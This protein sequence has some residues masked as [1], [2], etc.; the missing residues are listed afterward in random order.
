ME[1]GLSL[2]RKSVLVLLISLLV[3]FAGFMMFGRTVR[4]DESGNGWTLTDEG[5]LT[6][7]DAEAFNYNQDWKESSIEIKSVIIGGDIVSVPD[8]AFNDFRTITSVDLGN[9]KSVGYYSFSDCRAL[10][11]IDLSKLEYIDSFGFSYCKSLTSVDIRNVV[12]LEQNAFQACTSLK[13]VTADKLETIGSTVFGGCSK[14]ETFTFVNSSNVTS[15]GIGCFDSCEKLT[16]LDLSKVTSIPY[17]AFG[18]CKALSDLKLGDLTSISSDSFYNCQSLKEID[19]S[20]ITKIP[21]SAF[22][23]C[24]SLLKVNLENVTSI[25]YGA[26]CGCTSLYSVS[27][28]ENVESIDRLAFKNCSALE[29]ELNL[30][31]VSSIPDEAFYGCSAITIV[32]LSTTDSVTIG[33]S[34]FY[35]CTKLRQVSDGNISSV[36]KE[37]FEFCTALINIEL[38][39]ASTIS[40]SAFSGCTKLGHAYMDNVK[41]IGTSAFASCTNMTQVRLGSDLTVIEQYTFKNCKSLMQ[42]NLQYVKEIKNE[43]FY[44]CENL[45]RADLRSVENIRANA[46]SGSFI[47]FITISPALE[48]I[49]GGFPVEQVNTL[50]FVGSKS[51]TRWDP[52]TVFPNALITYTAFDVVFVNGDQQEIQYVDKN[53]NAV[54]PEDLTMTD[55]RFTGWY[56]DNTFATLFDFNTRIT[57]D[58]TLY[59]GWAKDLSSSVFKGYTLSLQG[60]IAVNFYTILPEANANNDYLKFT[61]NGISGSQKVYLKDSET[62]V[63]DGNTYH[64]F[65]CR[66]PAKN[67]TSKITAEL[68]VNGEVLASNEYSVK[69]Y[70]LYIFEH[71]NKYQKAIPLVRAM[72]N[73]GAYAQLY[74]NCNT[75]D[76]AN[77]GID[78]TGYSL[79][80]AVF[81][82]P[83]DSGK[84]KL[85]N[86][87]T[88]SGVSA[89]FESDTIL[90]LRFTRSQ[91]YYYYTFILKD[92]TNETVIT[93]EYNGNEVLIK[94][95]NIPAHKLDYDFEIDIVVDGDNTK[96]R[97]VYSPMTYAYNIITREKDAVRTDELK[98]LMKS[99]YLYNKEAKKYLGLA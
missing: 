54:K 96:Y 44:G 3:A 28:L 24:T 17:T 26:F 67:M 22:S 52:Q 92:G 25:G 91:T 36:G 95:T 90:K 68:Y 34:A 79:N 40:D 82:K 39:K 38:F 16:S 69:E 8:F 60:D 11:D 88:F 37:A 19:L 53:R 97:V 70:A 72:L 33:K 86:G 20:N 75:D 51:Q 42:I 14:L 12:T 74:F 9:V 94:I 55:F 77:A 50:T 4:A 66:V 71:E 29:G 80:D 84:T 10:T 81:S 83:Y 46:F 18:G 48:N 43:A 15:I 13:S 98:N 23:N 78:N 61:V 30:G 93:P 64:V 5:V 85:P 65:K 2:S 31:K 35:R 99:F 57:K 87:L 1:K 49:W 21:D 47:R 45:V 56:T 6:I 58:I 27:S 59:A 41:S 62:I 63:S 7:T 73:Y 76:L 32:N 89:T